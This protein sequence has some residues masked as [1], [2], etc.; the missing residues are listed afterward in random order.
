[1][2]RSLPRLR[3]PLARFWTTLL[4]TMLSLVTFAQRPFITTWQTTTVNESITIPVND[5]VAGY[6]FTVEWGDGNTDAGQ[7]GDATHTYAA[8][9]TYTVSI[10]GSFPAIRLGAHGIDVTDKLMSI[11]QWGD[12][13][14]SSMYGA[15]SGASNMV[16]NATDAPNLSGVSSLA[17]MFYGASSLNADL[18]GWNVSGI[19]DMTNMFNGASLFNGNISGWDVS[20]VTNMY[21][22]FWYAGAFNQDIGGWTVSQVENMSYLFYSAAD[23]NQDLSGW[24]VSN[25]TNMEGMF[26]FTLG[27]DQSLGDWDISGV[28]D[29]TEMFQSTGLSPENYSATL[30][31]WAPRS[32]QS[33]IA[34]DAPNL[35]YCPG[36]A[37]ANARQQLLDKGWTIND[38]GVAADCTS[39]GGDVTPGDPANFVTTWK[40]D[41]NGPS[42]D[43][44]ISV[45]ATGDFNYI[46]ENVAN[47]AETGSG[48]GSGPT[49]ITFPQAGTYKLS[50]QSTGSTPFHKIEF[51]QVSADDK[52]KILA[53]NN[54]GTIPWSGFQFNG[55]S[56]L[57]IT[58]TDIPDLSGVTD[59]S[60]AFS[61]SGIESIPNIND[62]EVG[63]VTDLG[64]FFEEV[65]GFNQS[66]SNWDVSKVTDMSF[67]FDGAT[68]FN[69]PL[70]SWDVSSLE[71]FDYMFRNASSFNQSLGAWN[72]AS[73]VGG[74]GVF[75]NSGLSCENYSYTLYGWATN[76]NTKEG[77]LFNP[78]APMQ[79]SPDVVPY[80]DFL[81]NDLGWTE[82]Y[83]DALGTCSITL[84]GTPITPDADN[85]LYVDINVNTTAT[86]Y[87]GAGNSWANA[88]PELADALKWAREQHDGGTPGWTETEPLRIFVAVGRY[89]PLY[90]AA[91]GQYTTD[92]G[93]DNSFVLV[94]DVQLYGGFD[95]AN[96]IETLEDARILPNRN[97]LGGGSVL[98]GDFL[99]NDNADNFANH[100]ENAYHVVI[101]SGEVGTARVDGFV[102]TGGH[103]D[104]ADPI[105]V[106]GENI[107]RQQGGGMYNH[108][109]S[110]TLTRIS[111]RNNAA[112][113]G[114]GMYVNESSPTLTHV[115]IRDNEA[116]TWGGGIYSLESSPKLLNVG[117]FD[118]TANDRGS[119]ILHGSGIM[120]ITNSTIA[121]N[122]PNTFDHSGV[123]KL[124]NTIVW[125][126]TGELR[127]AYTN[128]L[129][130]GNTNTDNGNIDATG[131]T[132]ADIFVDPDNGDYTLN[133]SSPAINAG[134][135]TAYTNAGGNL[136]EDLDLAGN[137]RIYVGIPDP[138]RIDIG[139]YEY[140]GE[141][142]P[143]AVITPDG[144]NILY[145]DIN[146]NTTVTGYTGAGDSWA[147]A[148]PELADALKWAR[149]QHDEGTPSWTDTDPLRVFVAKGEYKPLYSAADLQY[150]ADGGRINSFVLV[151]D[152]Q[153]YGGFDPANGI[154]TLE[155]ARILPDLEVD[156]MAGTV[157][158]GDLN[159][160]DAA[161]IP[162]MDLH[163][164]AS[165]Q[166]N[167]HHVVLAAGAVGTARLDGFA[168]TGGNAAGTAVGV[169]ILQV[170]NS[171]IYNDDNGGG[172]STHYSSPTISHVVLTGNSAKDTGGGMDSYR[173]PAP[174]LS[175]VIFSGNSARSGGGMSSNESSPTLNNLVFVGNEATTGG[176]MTIGLSAPKLSNVTITGN[177]AD[178]GGGMVIAESSATITNTI[179]WGN[180][181]GGSTTSVS[182]SIYKVGF[183]DPK[184]TISYSLI[185]NLGGSE[186]WDEELGID[187]G[188][189]IDADP[190]FVSTTPGEAGYLRLSACSPAI[191]MGDNQ[192]YTDAGG[193]LVNDLDL[194]GN[195]RV[196]N[197]TA[198]G[199]IDMGAYEYQGERVLVQSLAIPDAVQVAYGTG[200]GEVAGLPTAVTA[201]LSDDTDVSIPLDGNLANW[202]LTSPAGGAY[203][204]DVAGTYVFT[205]PLL[206][207]ETECYLNPENLR[208][209]ITIVVAKG[210]PVLAASWNGAA[211]DVVEGLSLTY[212][213][214]GELLLSTTDTDGV[215][216][217]ALGND[218]T[219]V[220]E[221]ADLSA[222]AAQQAGTA[223][224]TIAQKET[225]NYEAASI[226]FSISVAPKAI[227]IVPTGG[228]GKVYGANEPTGYGYELPDGSALAFDDE[229]TD[230]VSAASREAGEDVGAYDIEL[231]FGGDQA[232]N[233]A[234]TF[235]TGNNAFEITP[236]RIAVTAT[237]KSKVFGAGDPALTYT[238]T[239]EL[240]GE[241]AFTGG[242]TREEG[243][244]VGTY[245]ITQGDLSLSDNYEMTFEPGTLTIT[246]LE[247]TV[248]AADKTK[249]FGTDDPTLTYTFTPE[250]IGDDAFTGELDRAEGQ[251]VGTYAITQGNLSLG[252]N[253]EITFGEGTLTITPADYEGIAFNDGSFMYDG[254]GHVLELTGELPEG[255]SVTYEIDGGAGNGAT[256][257]GTYEITALIDG[258]SNYEDSELTATLTI[259]PLK[260]TITVANKTKVFGADD[261]ALTYTFTPELIGDDTFT[262]GL[263]REEGE[264]VGD[265]AITQG[266]LS[267]GDNY[268]ITFN[269]GTLTI[270]SA[271]YEGVSFKNTSSTYDGT[272]HRLTLSGDLP[273]GTSVTYENNGR[274]NVGSQT[275]TARIAG[276]ENYEDVTLTA[277]LE[278]TPL[279]IMVT[280]DDKRKIFGAEDP[281]LT[282][283]SAPELIGDDTFTGGLTRE[284]GEGAGDYGILQGNLSAGDNYAITFELGTLTITQPVPPTEITGI[285]LE[286][287]T[288]PYDGTEHRL[289]IA[290]DLPE[291]VSVTYESNGRTNAGSQTVTAR[292]SG[293]GYET[294][295]LTAT[296]TIA[297]AARSIDFPA[298]P[299]KTYGD[300]DFDADAVASSGEEVTYT[301][302]NPR[303]ADVSADGMITITGAGEA[304]ITVTV[305]ENGNYTSRPRETRTLVVHKAPQTITFNAPAEVDRDAGS[306]QLDVS[307]SSGLPVSLT[308]DDEQVATLDGSTLNILRLGTIQ[309][310][311]MQA[312]DANY[313]AA[314]RVTVTVRVVDPG[315]DLPVRVHPVISPNG[316]GINEF[317]MIEAVK[318]YPENR[319]T[320]FNRNGTL[321]WEAS[322]YDN[323]RI[324]FR[325]IS[326]G[327]LLLPAGTYFY[328]VEVKD[329]G[330]WKHKKGY[331]VLRY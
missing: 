308:I 299:E 47:P 262:G 272:E 271:G 147:N 9:G 224:L 169:P 137:P 268:T 241:D 126:D 326:T 179:I 212:G 7:T 213:D 314:E 57:K 237:D 29:M 123:L 148:I 35:T 83:G 174:K 11:E 141:P 261:P 293:E 79:Y 198:A 239:P 8:A 70:D 134:S 166:D 265:Y 158:N 263:T 46:W 197:F 171:P 170:N 255:V 230:I 90:S 73:L 64:N 243:E 217:Y 251:R 245:A 18:S 165:R 288:F 317:L 106:N 322:G 119:G 56:N 17:R 97:G 309:I 68:S 199:V 202:T 330:T 107:R 138:D 124:S 38:A 240:I 60:F 303:V 329:G 300:A 21:G 109:S 78:W 150:H 36:T 143:A 196:Y 6:N 115:S 105:I 111:I 100:M 42:E 287:A 191:S 15:F 53:I 162:V 2:E 125:G 72:L 312:G 65:A 43:N 28:I 104:G 116:Y 286:D 121:G 25:V 205:V 120:E 94:A 280:A 244:D 110:P 88:I 31:G 151:A 279:V 229:L 209:E 86:G 51:Y 133:A 156:V 215:V 194:A 277:E 258:G 294:L 247:I 192:G 136:V 59:L 63:N 163:S 48:S 266:D 321:L 178:D 207:P 264:V 87:T 295:V 250:L 257:A 290:G 292:M 66:L 164:H 275:V 12:I 20:N 182:A 27:F 187:G 211:I 14:W 331:F 160:D 253:Y 315:S 206:V 278:V 84:P 58:A 276:G 108:F 190:V 89:L 52:L 91:D 222:V 193:D 159:G 55:S 200:L 129:I 172:I 132:A 296:L 145:V 75:F 298:L 128:S 195:P 318:D 122:T 175:H 85:I 167:A 283:T 185:A 153:L 273:G 142:E 101:G 260:V 168:I 281:A 226:A 45:P 219:P 34:L 177:S 161:D 223:T 4:F 41:N 19:T 26:S 76:P 114:G 218:D 118:N 242:L 319:V 146:V 285:A 324:A 140:Q 304:V 327:Q 246:P 33:G 249:V 188:G 231:A 238:F 99:G 301:S 282:Y 131:L 316:D 270:V 152:V 22:M 306:V 77:V 254:T 112:E 180:E 93:R 291:G 233:Y 98:S 80:R 157:L 307:A 173:M 103:A 235:E 183:P 95:P 127:V 149:E 3:M 37:V 44:Q 74:V 69:Q 61:H 176:G 269:V 323:N 96:G 67:M 248:A 186:N 297:P 32:V 302:E 23:F 49:T 155:D 102:V 236:L 204:G 210:T 189:N 320:I 259:T 10:T 214:V 71:Q 313:E 216:T 201:S 113:W 135:N 154:E 50:I 227:T 220:L 225:G 208:A 13:A 5:D 325:G 289:S 16:L 252:A 39:G 130:E 184:P 40:T 181:A 92:G 328:I 274:T 24:S 82:F 81:I 310:T 228:Q 144:D 256:D 232:G 234:I 311:A 305:P 1:M 30:V 54:W 62:W 284:E 139:A 117:I 267:A 203:D 221:L